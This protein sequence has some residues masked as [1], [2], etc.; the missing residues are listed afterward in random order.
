MRGEPIKELQNGVEQFFTSIRADEVAS[1][2]AE[3]SII[4]FGGDV[5]VALDFRSIENQIVP[6]L[7]A[8]GLTPMGEAVDRALD[9]LSQRKQEYRNAGVD[10]YQPWL[11]LMSDGYP[12]DDITIASQRVS[13]LVEDRKLTVFPIGIGEGA[14]ME[15]LKALGGGR[16]PLRLK[17]LNFGAFFQ[18]LSRSVARVSQ[19]T[20]GE[21]VP[22][23]S[24]LDSWA[25]I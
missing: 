1:S 9:I 25:E 18:W 11:V 22:L 3:I 15:A 16:A 19:S 13:K 23:P 17:G 10:Y 4:T 20:P 7:E 8:S 24:D 2:S 12:T 5:E 14:D 6:N 21:R